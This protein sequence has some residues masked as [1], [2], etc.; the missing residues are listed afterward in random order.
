MVLVLFLMM[1]LNLLIN[2]WGRPM[3]SSGRQ[4]ADMM[5]MMMNLIYSDSIHRTTQLVKP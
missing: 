3:S 2:F 4:S 1:Q 5:M